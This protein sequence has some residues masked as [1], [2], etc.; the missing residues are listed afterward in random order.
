M[1]DVVPVVV[2]LERGQPGKLLG[3]I[4]ATYAALPFVTKDV[5]IDAAG[6]RL[7]YRTE[8]PSG[9]H[10]LIVIS[11]VRPRRSSDELHQSVAMAKGTVLIRCRGDCTAVTLE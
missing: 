11:W 10:P 5:D 1:E 7:H 4:G 6:E 2:P 8:P 9:L 3:R